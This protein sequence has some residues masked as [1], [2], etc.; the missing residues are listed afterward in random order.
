M[1]ARAPA[2]ALISLTALM[3]VAARPAQAAPSALPD[4]LGS[5]ITAAK[6]A[7]QREDC[8]GVLGALDPLVPGLDKGDERTFVQRM[9]LLCLGRENRLDELGKVQRELVELLPRDGVVRAFGV[10]IA[11]DERRF[12]DAADQL[13]TLAATSPA[14]LDMLSAA[15]IREISNQL[16]RADAREARDKMLIALARSDW[17][18]ADHPDM[19]TGFAEVAIR[20]LVSRGD[21]AEAE[22]LL[23][24]IDEPELLTAM[25]VD[26]QYMALWPTIEARLGPAGSVAADRYARASLGTFGTSPNS[27]TALRDA[28]DA[29]LMLGRYQDVVDMTEQVGVATGMSREA[30]Q[31]ILLRA[32]ALAM[33]KRGDV[34]E[35]MLRAFTTIDLDRTPD[36]T[37]ALITHAELLDEA[38]RSAQ[39]LEAARSARVRAAG[40]LNDFGL[41]WLDR[42]EVCTLSALGRTAEAAAALGRLKPLA[43]QNHAAVIEALLCAHRDGEASALALEAFKDDDAGT[44]LVFQFQ[45][46][47]ALWAATPSRLRDLWA[48]FLARPEIRT[49]LERKGRVLPKPYWPSRAPRA[50]PRSPGSGAS[51]T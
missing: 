1:P 37:M 38:G 44:E 46:T 11:A 27:E 45:P 26:R 29:M 12:V 13:A 33:L 3:L 51:L 14:T 40:I 23:E 8:P 2:L 16:R 32:R 36:A 31:I 43:W 34:A 49:A 41:R 22:S 4:D 28:A 9:R 24:R 5:A 35:Q 30:V 39:G 48:G 18:P 21:T 6:A 20:A 17:A 7:A 19:R 50:I 10:L 25:M 47:G 15:A 42:T